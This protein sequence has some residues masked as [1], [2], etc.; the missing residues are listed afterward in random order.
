M[1]EIT[2]KGNIAKVLEIILGIF[3]L[4]TSFGGFSMQPVTSLGFLCLGIFF[5]VCGYQWAQ[6][7]SICKKYSTLLST[8]PKKSISTLATATNSSVATVRAN[9][10]MMIKKGLIENIAID[11]QSN[12]VVIK[13]ASNNTSSDTSSASQIS[14]TGEIL[15]PSIVVIECPG[16]GAKNKI[17]QGQAA[18]CDH[19]GSSING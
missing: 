6:L 14:S 1:G 4:L 18:E 2:S 11:E 7:R 16:C 9:I 17:P 19:C 10:Q 8:D 15:E 5:I 12:R 3:F 13:D